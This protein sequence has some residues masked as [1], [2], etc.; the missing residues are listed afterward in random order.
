[1]PLKILEYSQKSFFTEATNLEKA[2]PEGQWRHFK[3]M[4]SERVYGLF[5]THTADKISDS[6]TICP[7][8]DFFTYFLG[9]FKPETTNSLSIFQT[10]S[11]TDFC[12]HLNK[13]LN[14]NQ[15]V[16]DLSVAQ[17]WIWHETKKEHNPNTE[18]SKE[19]EML[20]PKKLKDYL[21]CL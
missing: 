16:L 12:I 17:K 13:I 15:K 9:L 3:F 8:K 6:K 11:F 1:M 10:E 5:E 20:M 21:N 19:E 7:H 4:D 14:D 2:F 18:K